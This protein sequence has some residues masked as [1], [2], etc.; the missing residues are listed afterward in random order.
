M[1]LTLACAAK[2]V[3]LLRAVATERARGLAFAMGLRERLGAGS[4]VR[5]LDPE[6]VRIVL[7]LV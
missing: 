5:A 2:M 1:S 4:P 3:A 7:D 6:V